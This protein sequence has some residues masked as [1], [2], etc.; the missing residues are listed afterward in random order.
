MLL[1]SHPNARFEWKKETLNQKPVKSLQLIIKP[2]Q[3]KTILNVSS[4]VDKSFLSGYL[5]ALTQ[6]NKHNYIQFHYVSV[7][8]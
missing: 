2:I 4:H 3:F 1:L 8:N 5:S 7:P 6:S